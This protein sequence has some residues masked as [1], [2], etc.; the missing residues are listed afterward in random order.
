MEVFYTPTI[1]LIIIA[2]I[3]GVPYAIIS[4]KKLREQWKE[5]YDSYE[6]IIVSFKDF[7]K[8]YNINPDVYDLNSY[9]SPVRDNFYF[10][11][12]TFRD[13]MKYIRWRDGKRNFEQNNN[14]E[15]LFAK[16]LQAD[17]DAIQDKHIKWLE[18]QKK[19]FENRIHKLNQ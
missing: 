4:Y 5:S 7:H 16:V 17:L 14:S 10:R 19:D 18:D 1:V 3:I 6:N 9:Y 11:F 12:S 15:N 8:Y 13:Y 2:T